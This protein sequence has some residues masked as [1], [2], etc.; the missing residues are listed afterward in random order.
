MT[1][2]ITNQNNYPKMPYVPKNPAAAYKN[3]T[4]KSGGCGACAGLNCLQNI[5]DVRYSVAAWIQKVIDCG[6]RY[7]GGTHINVMLNMLKAEKGFTWKGTN[8]V[9]AVKRHLQSGGGVIFHGGYGN[10]FSSAGH[11]VCIIGIS[12]SGKAIVLDSGWYKGKYSIN[13][14]A[15]KVHEWTQNGVLSVPWAYVEADKKYKRNEGTNYYLVTAPVKEEAPIESKE[16]EMKY[17]TINDVPKMYREAVQRRIDNGT[18]RGDGNGNIN[19]YESAA[20]QWTIEDRSR[21]ETLEDIPRGEFR[22]IIK[23]LMDK[24]YIKG[25]G[26]GVLDLSKDMVRTYVINYRAGLYR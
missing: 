14:R 17:K 1:Y 5:S 10:V 3:A 13:G 26:N 22:D 6:A 21:Y 18:L 2:L 4:V 16:E 15:K 8:D 20:W 9:N 24:G 23:E 12:D 11:F 7:N 25:N 19:V